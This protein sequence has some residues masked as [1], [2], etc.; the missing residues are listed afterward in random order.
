MEDN[1]AALKWCYN[2]I[3]HGKQKHIPVAYHFV[4]EQVSQFGSLNVVGVE[5]QYQLADL[6]TKIMPAPRMRF[7]VDSIRGLHP[8]PPIRPTP[9]WLES[10]TETVSESVGDVMFNLKQHIQSSAS[11]PDDKQFFMKHFEEPDPLQLQSQ[12]G[13][14]PSENSHLVQSL[15]GKQ[16]QAC[17][18]P[19]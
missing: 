18:N 10:A 13:V 15:M 6:F 11:E 17:S 1:Q 2:P 12:A 5:T 8:T 14:R 9:N 16:D 19:L 7:L 4:R 3:N